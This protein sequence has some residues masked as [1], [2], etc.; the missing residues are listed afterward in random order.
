M[1]PFKFYSDTPSYPDHSPSGAAV[2]YNQLSTENRFQQAVSIDSG[3]AAYYVYD[4][5]LPQSSKKLEFIFSDNGDTA[6]QR[7]ALI[8]VGGQWREEDW[9]YL[10]NRRFCLDRQGENVEA[11]VIIYSNAN[12]DA[13]YFSQY[14]VNTKGECPKEITGT[15]VMETSVTAPI[16]GGEYKITSKFVSRDVLQYDPEND[17]YLLKS[18]TVSCTSSSNAA[19]AGTDTY[20]GAPYLASLAAQG[21]CSGS[22]TFNYQD[23]PSAPEKIRFDREA[24]TVY[25]D[26]DPSISA[27]NANY[28]RCITDQNWGFGDVHLILK[29][30]EKSG[31][32]PSLGPPSLVD[33][34][35]LAE[36][37]VLRNGR[38]HK[39]ESQSMPVEGGTTTMKIVVD[40][41]LKEG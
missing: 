28:I 14:D 29:Q 6:H 22:A 21:D 9:T 40:Y 11:V 1:A 18:R 7:R 17:V 23:I 31:T 30:V 36:S 3:A 32:C 4:A 37:E 39:E 10:G 16:A 20:L 19:G 38:L 5:M 33:W 34:S 13:P 41:S 15:T 26:L 8:K 2:I 24:G 25:V 27:P 35:S 12:L